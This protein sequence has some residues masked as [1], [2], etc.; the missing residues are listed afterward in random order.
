MTNEEYEAQEKR[1]KEL[2]AKYYSNLPMTGEEI[3]EFIQ[4]REIYEPVEEEQT[5]K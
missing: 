5:D 2:A 1:Y 3:F 4:L